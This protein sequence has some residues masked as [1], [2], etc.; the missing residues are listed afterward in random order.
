MVSISNGIIMALQAYFLLMNF[1]VEKSYCLAP[2]SETSTEFLI[3]ETIAFCKENNPLFLARPDWLQAATCISAFIFPFGYLSILAIAWKDWWKKPTVIAI[4]LLFVGVKSY[5]IYFYH[6][7][8]F[9]STTPP[10][11]LVPYFAAEGPY[12]MSLAMCLVKVLDALAVI[13]KSK[14]A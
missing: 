9:L 14:T 10:Q 2:L 7:M 1:T 5:A 13:P 11:H 8:E 4:V 12:I 3:P 6:L